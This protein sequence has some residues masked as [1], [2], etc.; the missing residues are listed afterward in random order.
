MPRWRVGLLCPASERVGNVVV[1]VWFRMVQ[2]FLNRI[3]NADLR[4]LGVCCGGFKDCGNV[5]GRQK[6]HNDVV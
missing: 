3:V 5:A 4:H 2:A 6:W 1:S